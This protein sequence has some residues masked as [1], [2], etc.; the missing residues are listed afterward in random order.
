[1]SSFR[2]FVLVGALLA[3]GPLYADKPGNATVEEPDK[4]GVEQRLE[5]FDD[6]NGVTTCKVKGKVCAKAATGTQADGGETTFSRRAGAKGDWVLSLFGNFKK[7]ALAGNAQ[8]IFADTADSKA[9]GKR[10]ITAM[11]QGL[12]KAG[13]GVSA[14]V[15]LS[16]D[17]GFRPGHTYR[18]EIVQLIGG[19]EV[20]L[21]DGAF[22]L[23]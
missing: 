5:L 9:A 16:G 17:D 3:A 15:H 13:N 11:Y 12:V 18:V 1:M 22:T 8:F 10:E 20:S 6:N 2:S 14:R 19:K 7:A 4:E 21:A 23:K